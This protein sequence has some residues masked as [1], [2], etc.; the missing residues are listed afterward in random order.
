MSARFHARRAPCR[1]SPR[2][3]RSGAAVWLAVVFG[4]VVGVGAGSGPG[5]AEDP[6]LGVKP[7]LLNPPPESPSTLETQ[8]ATGYRSRLQ[9]EVRRL[10]LRG[11]RSD[12]RTLDR[13]KSFRRELSR[14]GRALDR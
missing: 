10:E 9:A 2:A 13:H 4:V 7:W 8:R 11:E 12:P 5:A 14:I 6:A 3:A 1:P